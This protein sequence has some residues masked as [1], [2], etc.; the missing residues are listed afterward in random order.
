MVE[1]NHISFFPRAIMRV[2]EQ[3]IECDRILYVLKLKHGCYYVGQSIKRCYEERIKKHFM[4]KGSSWTK[5]HPP[6]EIIEEYEFVSD[7]RGGEL[8]ENE[9]TVELMQKYG[10]EKVRGGFF[11]QTSMVDLEKNLARHGYIIKK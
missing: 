8:L 1:F 2:E 7:Y 10:I 6:I 11:S 3:F 5:L 9:K 4:K